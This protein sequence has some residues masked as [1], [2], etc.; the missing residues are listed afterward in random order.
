MKRAYVV[1]LACCAALGGALVGFSWVEVPPT[2][3]FSSDENPWQIPV[4]AGADE[5]LDEAYARLGQEAAW[6]APDAAVEVTA[7]EESKHQAQ[8]WHFIGTVAQSDARFALVEIDG[9]VARYRVGDILPDDGLVVSI[10]VAQIGVE[11]DAEIELRQIFKGA[12]R[13]EV[14]PKASS[15]RPRPSTQQGNYWGNFDPM[16]KANFV[17]QRK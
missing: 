9:K 15:T 11:R 3:A 17:P 4:H 14:E 6:R 7:I 13:T 8:K 5:A 12:A 16:D 1:A 10:D 2:R